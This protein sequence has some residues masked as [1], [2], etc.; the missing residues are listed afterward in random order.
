MTQKEAKE[1]TLEM[2]RYLADNPDFLTKSSLPLYTYARIRGLRNRC[3]LCE[4]FV[5]G[6]E[7]RPCA[8]CPL[9]L[10][11]GLDCTE[12]GSAYNRWV[13]AETEA[14]RGKA[15]ERI[16]EIVSAWE[17]EEETAQGKRRCRVCGCTDDDCHQCI[18]KTG[19]PCH[20]VED[21][22]CSACAEEKV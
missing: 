16:V 22:L 19:K 20:W 12:E 8:F 17:P 4:L 5:G 10:A 14:E 9:F 11:E 6:D 15:A 18:E 1:L 2:W 21:D 3:P 7:K 13:Y